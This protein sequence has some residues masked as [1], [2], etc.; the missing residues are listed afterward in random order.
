[1]SFPRNFVFIN[2]ACVLKTVDIA[3]CNCCVVDRYCQGPLQ[4]L[5]CVTFNPLNAELNPICHLLALAEARHFVDVSRIRVKNTVSYQCTLRP[6][7]RSLTD[8]DFVAWFMTS[9]L[10]FSPFV[11]FVD[12]RC[13]T[14]L[15]NPRRF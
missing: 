15:K 2:Q 1:M 14:M 13:F 9:L 6:P 4:I 8:T 3:K 12:S 10:R 11:Y 7:V 5:P